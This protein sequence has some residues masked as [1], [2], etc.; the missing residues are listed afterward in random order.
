[1]L[2]LVHSIENQ[3]MSFKQ[4][5]TYLEN[6]FNKMKNSNKAIC[7]V[8]DTNFNLIDYKTSIKVKNH[9]LNNHMHS[10]I[11]TADILDNFPIFLI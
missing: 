4:Y 11:I 5:K 10:G 9:L 1:M 3:P 6:F 2:S 8:D 7:I